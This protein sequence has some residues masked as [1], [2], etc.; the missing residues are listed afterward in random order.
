MSELRRFTIRTAAGDLVEVAADR[1]KVIGRHVAER[2]RR[3]LLRHAAYP[4][5][6][7]TV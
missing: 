1:I 4:I 5:L 3:R 6:R 2:Q 7:K